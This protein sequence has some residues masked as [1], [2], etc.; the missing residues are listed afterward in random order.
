[1]GS[2]TKIPYV[3]ASWN[4]VTGCTP[5]SEGCQNCYARPFLNRFRGIEGHKFEHGF[6]VRMHQKA[7]DEPRNWKKPRRVFVCSVSDLYHPDVNPLFRWMV[8]RTMRECF[9]HTF[10]VLTK[11]PQQMLDDL[12]N[13]TMWADEIKHEGERCRFIHNPL[14]NVW[15]GVTAENQQTADE[16]IPILLQCP[17]AVRFVSCEP[18]LGRVDLGDA[19]GTCYHSAED[20]DTCTG[21]VSYNHGV[22]WVIVG[23][24]SGPKARPCNVEHIRSLVQQCRAAD[25]PVFVKQLGAS[26]FDSATP[27]KVDV[28]AMRAITGNLL[29]LKDRKGG[30]PAEWPADLRVQEFPERAT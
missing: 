11:R 2:T 7:L 27:V 1:M 22:D 16:R 28:Q 19:F 18:L 10:L 24:E 8:W 5:E 20:G 25:V 30:D 9:Q 21:D 12:A 6:D 26:A 14:P 3:T 15:L 29:R 4:P 13:N 17:A 23:G